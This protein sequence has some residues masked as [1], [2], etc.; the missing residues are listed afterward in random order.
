MKKT[1]LITGFDGYCGWPLTLKLMKTFPDWEFVGVD[2]E[3]RRLWVDEIKAKSV[4]SI[5]NIEER[6][7]KAKEIFGVDMDDFLFDL[8]NTN[9]VY[10]IMYYFKP[11]IVLHLASQP[12]APYSEIDI[13]HCNFTQENNTKMLRNL[14]WAIKSFKLKTHLVVTTTTG[15]YGAP[16]FD[17]PEG[18]LV[19]NKMEMPFPSM[20]GSWYHMSRAMDADN[21]WLAHRQF[22]IPITELR[23]SIVAGSST[24]ET[25]LH[26]TLATR[27]DTDFYFGVVCNRFVMMALDK[28]PIT[29]YGKGLQG[30]PMISLEEMCRSI[31]E[32]CKVEKPEGY[33]IYNQM[34]KVMPIRD[35]AY[36]I[37]NSFKKEFNFDVEV[38]HISN[39]RIENEEHNMKMDNSKFKKLIGGFKHTLEDSLNQICIDLF[40]KEKK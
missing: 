6:V 5:S 27:F 28:K 32:V 40:P 11:D 33:K 2:N 18:N 14:V 19:V 25:R 7:I 24:E 10:D 1:V 26:P 3:G 17:I 36:G 38:T 34:E 21:L 13:D 22:G 12:S 20:G 9:Q 39:P 35:L 30:K 15:I 16:D 8:T 4:I 29:I 37:K 23:T 31:I